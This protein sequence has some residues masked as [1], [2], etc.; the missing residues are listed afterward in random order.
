MVIV[1]AGGHAL[2]LLDVLVS[3][4]RSDGLFFFDNLTSSKNRLFAGYSIL[5]TESELITE[6][7]RDPTVILGTGNVHHRRALAEYCEK[8]GGKLMSV[9]SS[10]SHISKLNVTLGQGVN[11]MRNVMI[12]PGATIGEGTLVNAHVLIHHES[13]IGEYCEICPGVIIAGNVSIGDNTMIGAGAVILPKI[14]IGNNVTVGAGAVVLG[15]IV[16]DIVVVGNPAR[17]ASK[18]LDN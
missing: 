1:G 5:R 10:T 4:N 8:L 11:V 14:R 7:R 3:D 13:V 16:D 17:I 6:L 12:G 18:K 9:V 15:D 2:E